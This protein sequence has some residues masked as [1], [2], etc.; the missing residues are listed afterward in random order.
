M[1]VTG[2]FAPLATLLTQGREAA[3]PVAR[4]S[5]GLLRFDAFVARVSAIHDAVS[6]GTTEGGRW[7]VVAASSASFA[8]ALLAVWHARGVV[9]LPP[10]AQPATLAELAQEAVGIVSDVDTLPA[11]LRVVRPRTADGG[12][13]TARFEPLDPSRPCLELLSSGTTSVR[14]R[15]SKALSQL[16]TELEALE[17]AFGRGLVGAEVLGSVSHQHVYGLLIRVL[18]PLA[19]GRIFHTDPVLHAEEIAARLP[20]T[21]QAVFVSV[22]AQIRTLARGQVLASL[23]PI[24]RD[25]FSSGGPLDEASAD[26]VAAGLGRAPLEVYGS[27]ESGGIGWR[28][29]GKGSGRLDWT[30]LPGVRLDVDAT[31][32]LLR[33]TSPFASA[34]AHPEPLRTADRAMLLPDGR[35]RLLGRADRI[36]K[37]AEKA[38]SL[39]E[40]EEHLC[41]HP[42]VDAA[43]CL[44]LERRGEARIGAVVVASGAGRAALEAHGRAQLGRALASHLATR[45]D[46]IVIP[47]AWRYVEALPTD[48]QG[49]LALAA[50]EALFASADARVRREP[51]RLSELRGPDF[52]E[53]R[54]RIPHQLVALD[55]HF[56]GLPIVPGVAQLEWVFAAAREGLGVVDAA[57]RIDRLKFRSIVRPGRTLCVRVERVPGMPAFDFRVFDGEEV[58]S[59]GRVVFGSVAEPSA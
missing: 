6:D 3:H 27:T 29:Q 12:R 28:R 39:P 23:S 2:R 17:T 35:F 37:I 36:V 38:V 7:L 13:C 45:W 9:V 1:S 50:L 56:P 4:E 54:L 21:V 25:V 22:P 33:V 15:C 19:A 14:K 30:P 41:E 57:V 40:L 43:A 34:L 44:R 26:A 53:R 46:R 52:V 24:L 49:K 55:G 59:S 51:E 10:N 58:F 5:G 18:W 8:A 42:W 32:Q 48:A 16:D 31:T 47:R 20:A 11:G